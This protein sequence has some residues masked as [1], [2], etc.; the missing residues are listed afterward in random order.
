MQK[1]EV[2]LDI[3]DLTVEYGRG[4]KKFKAI[5][6]V[7]F[8]IYRGEI[9]GLVGESGS[10]K[11]TIGKAILR[12]VK[13]SG[14]SIVFKGK[15][16]NGKIDRKLDRELKRKIQMVFQDPMASL[17][18]RAKIDYIVSEGLYNIRNFIDENHRRK[19]VE[20]ILLDVGL[21]PE[22]ANYFPHEFSG[23]M[24]QRIGIARALIMEPE[25]LI[26]DEP[27]SALD[28]STRF[29]IIN[30]LKE[31]KEKRNLTYLFITHD[32]SLL[33]SL[34]HRVAVMYKGKIVEL[35]HTEKL[36]KNPIHPYTKSLIFA[37]PIPDPMEER[38]KLQYMY[39]PLSYAYENKPPK[40]IEV[41]EGHFVLK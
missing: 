34:A 30:L 3:K 40:L 4:R 33:R 2:I 9:F 20:K 16:I 14:G 38:N 18:E 36:F 29:Q 26:L 19:K 7:S 1:Q 25:F 10:G 12:I 39:D 28:L 32:L 24:R 6:G 11:T 13:T 35:A 15:K 21:L 5:D 22:H 41:E 27:T 23:G 37:I 31:L 8:S 17:N